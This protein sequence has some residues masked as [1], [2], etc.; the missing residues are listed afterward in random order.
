VLVVT[1]GCGVGGVGYVVDVSAFVVVPPASFIVGSHNLYY[2][3][4]ISIKK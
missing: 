4:I 3:T 1:R 2:K